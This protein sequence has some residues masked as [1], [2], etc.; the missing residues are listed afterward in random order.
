MC[1]RDRDKKESP[2]EFPLISIP[3]WV[4]CLRFQQSPI[5]KV[6]T[7]IK[8]KN[9]S[10]EAFSQPGVKEREWQFC[11]VFLCGDTAIGEKGPPKKGSTTSLF[12]EKVKE[13]YKHKFAMSSGEE[14]SDMDNCVEHCNTFIVMANYNEQR[15]HTKSSFLH[16]KAVAFIH[17]L[18]NI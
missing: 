1:I 10:K 14:E 3:R 13:F 8:G 9:K 4:K 12:L 17:I 6:C 18:N 7:P 5:A 2:T 11:V 16:S 15:N